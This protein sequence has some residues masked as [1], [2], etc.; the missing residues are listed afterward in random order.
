MSLIFD[1]H[2][3]GLW[4]PGVG[5]IAT[6]LWMGTREIL[7][8]T[9]TTGVSNQAREAAKICVSST[10][11]HVQEFANILCLQRTSIV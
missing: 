9:F 5:I 4:A 7:S 3:S 6:L 10:K 11:V 2:F 1:H 8:A